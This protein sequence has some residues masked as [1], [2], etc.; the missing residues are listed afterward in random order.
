METLNG[1]LEFVEI[2]LLYVNAGAIRIGS[3]DPPREEGVCIYHVTIRRYFGIEK[4]I[5][6]IHLNPFMGLLKILV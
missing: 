5:N 1:D 3:A 4:T 2:F 6:S